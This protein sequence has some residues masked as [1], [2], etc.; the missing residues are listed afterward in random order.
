MAHGARL[1]ELDLNPVM[2]TP[3]GVL[4]VDW[5]MVLEGASQ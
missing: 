1:R 5:L 3:G 4:A 2:A